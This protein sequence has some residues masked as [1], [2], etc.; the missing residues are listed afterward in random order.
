[1][2]VYPALPNRRMAY[3]EDGTLITEYLVVANT[4]TPKGYGTILNDESS[5][6]AV[7]YTNPSLGT[8]E[9][10][11]LGFWFPEAR[12]VDYIFMAHAPGHSGTT[13]DP[14]TVSSIDWSS[15]ATSP[16]DVSG[17]TNVGAAFP[18]ISAV[19]PAYRQSANWFH[20]NITSCTTIRI[21]FAP[22]ESSFGDKSYSIYAVHL[23]GDR[24]ATS[25]R[26]DFR[27][28]TATGDTALGGDYFNWNDVPQ[29]DNQSK[30]FRL[31]NLSTTAN[32][33]QTISLT[34]EAITD[35]TPSEVA[36]YGFTGG[37]GTAVTYR[38]QILTPTPLLYLPLDDPGTDDAN[39]STVNDSSGSTRNFTTVGTLSPGFAQTALINSEGT[40]LGFSGTGNS[41]YVNRAYDALFDIGLGDFTI[42]FMYYCNTASTLNNVEVWGRT[43]ASV[44]VITFLQTATNGNMEV[45]L[46]GNGYVGNVKINDGVVHHITIKRAGSILSTYVDGVRDINTAANVTLT[47][48]TS[49]TWKI[50][51]ARAASGEYFNGRI[52]HFAFWNAAISDA[53]IQRHYG[54]ASVFSG[55][56]YSTLWTLASLAASTLTSDITVRKQDQTNAGL[57]PV[58]ARFNASALTW[59]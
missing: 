31:K 20:V 44:D 6:T 42:E 51:R 3:D 5:S 53:Q 56:T 57:G 24:V 2:P 22:G 28:N 19:S 21:V 15:T 10:Y 36:R 48:G 14:G 39:G 4:V 16:T 38:N 50:G 30:T 18:A 41:N 33:A 34:S 27:N 1:M 26:L 46:N 59:T 52:G 13:S 32:T 55:T 23:Y 25:A 37:A 43:D 17:W 29:G 49:P 8:N 40:S 35:S 7:S 9:T 45:I 12:N 11:H 54:M 47:A 58:A